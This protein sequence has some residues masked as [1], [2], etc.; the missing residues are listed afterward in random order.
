MRS[1]MHSPDGALVQKRE[2][3]A[4]DAQALCARRDAMLRVLSEWV[5]TT[6]ILRLIAACA[7]LLSMACAPSTLA[8]LVVPFQY[9]AMA[10]PTEFPL[11]QT[12]SAVSVVEALDSRTDASLGTRYLEKSPATTYPVTSS[13]DAVAWARSGIEEALRRARVVVRGKPAPI[14]RIAVEH[15]ST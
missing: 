2:R 9:K 10:D 15:V 1:S 12:C 8:P 4:G 6:S 5:S 11:L 3:A 7:L 14:L 13:G